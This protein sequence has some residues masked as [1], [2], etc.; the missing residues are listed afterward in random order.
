MVIRRLVDGAE[1]AKFHGMYQVVTTGGW[2][3]IFHPRGVAF[4]PC[5]RIGDLGACLLKDLHVQRLAHDLVASISGF[6]V[7]FNCCL[8][9]GV[10]QE[11]FGWALKPLAQFC[12]KLPACAR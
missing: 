9:G 6:V 1:T 4:A 8:H 10:A 5:L 12:E 2:P 7:G 11:T 3:S